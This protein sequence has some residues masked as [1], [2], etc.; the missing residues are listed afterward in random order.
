MQPIAA[1]RDR[2]P[3]CRSAER[4]DLSTAPTPIDHS[5][6]H[7]ASPGNGAFSLLNPPVDSLYGGP[8]WKLNSVKPD[9]NAAS[10][11][12]HRYRQSQ[13]F[14][15]DWAGLFGTDKERV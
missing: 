13:T 2:N 15:E 5:R 9:V 8:V 1:G 11:V 7:C 10:V 12:P 6:F 14:T 4:V 3:W